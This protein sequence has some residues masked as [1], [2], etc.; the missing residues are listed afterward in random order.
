MIRSWEF[1]AT[2]FENT[3]GIFGMKSQFC[4]KFG[5]SS[6]K[7]A[8]LLVMALPWAV[9]AQ[10]GAPDILKMQAHPPLHRLVTANHAHPA[11]LAA[12][13]PIHMRTVY[14]FNEIQNYGEGQIIGIVDAYDDP[15]IES[16]LAVYDTAMLLPE[17]TTA[18]GCFTKLYETGTVPPGDTTGWSNEIAIDVEWSHTIAPAAQI[19][20]VEANSNSFNDLFTAVNVAV[21][22]GASVVSM[23]WSGGEDSS[24][25]STDSYFDV[26]G[27][28]F[29]AASGDTGHGIGYPASSPYVVGVGAT[30][31]SLDMVTAA[32]ESE[33][34][35]SG[36]SGGSSAFEPEPAYQTA[37]QNTGMRGVPD[38][39]YDGDPSTGVPAFSSNACEFCY[40]GWDQWGG[41]S[42]GT[43]EWAALIAI[44]NSQRVAMGKTTLSKIQTLLY[45]LSETDYHDIT[46]GSNGGCGAQCNA[47]PGYDFVTG[48]G[49]PQAN[50]LIP[51]LVAAP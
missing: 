15:T 27:V 38:V 49:S 12:V 36:S 34:A 26:N 44:A 7:L 39:A 11:A 42:I 8:A 3:K 14:G 29:V 45:P 9:R 50:L 40:T 17:C 31:L 43:P 33:T 19:V 35:W 1:V 23:S 13:F 25:L 48:L 46:S 21:A 16:D 2:S 6:V 18:N 5:R 41:T 30:T 51:A 10:V 24:E 47:G 28:T 32:W 4:V 22:A 37:Y 20:L